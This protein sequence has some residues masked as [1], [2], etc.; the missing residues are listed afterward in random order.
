MSTLFT[1]IIEG[2]IPGRIVWEDDAVVGFLDAFPQTYGHALVVP[3]E[4]IDLWTDL[5]PELSAHVFEV[6]RTIGRAQ[7]AAF[8]ADRVGVIVQGYL[9]PHAHVHVFPTT[10]AA[11][12]D[13]ARQMKDPDPKAMDEA[14]ASLRRALIDAGYEQFVPAH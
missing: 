6:A 7:L 8:E 12:F 5:S 10:S 9:V 1:K 11:D 2:E 3:R 14:A 4:E 13:P